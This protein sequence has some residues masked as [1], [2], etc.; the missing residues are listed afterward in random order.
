VLKLHAVHTA[1]EEELNSHHPEDESFFPP[2][3]TGEFRCQTM[4]NGIE[5]SAELFY[6]RPG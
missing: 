1:I 6:A 4:K 5:L 2:A 3:G